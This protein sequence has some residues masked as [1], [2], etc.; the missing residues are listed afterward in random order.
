MRNIVSLTSYEHQLQVGR[1]IRY[2][3]DTIDAD[4]ARDLR[5]GHSP[6]PE[7]G[8]TPHQVVKITHLQHGTKF[9]LLWVPFVICENLR[10]DT[11]FHP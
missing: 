9:A 8:K 11:S 2:D 6:R 1:N 7:V 4:E 3:C 10:S 5:L